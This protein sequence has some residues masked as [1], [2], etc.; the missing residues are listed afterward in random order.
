MN[1]HNKAIKILSKEHGQKI[2]QFLIDNGI[3]IDG[4]DI[5][6]NKQDNKCYI[7]G[8]QNNTIY[9]VYSFDNLPSK[10]EFFELP[11][12][13]SFPRMMLVWDDNESDVVPRLVL[14]KSKYNVN[15]P[16]MTL[17]YIDNEKEA[18]EKFNSGEIMK[19]RFCKYAKE[20][21]QSQIEV[22][23]MTLEQVCKILGKEIKIIK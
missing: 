11:E 17:S 21:E 4:W 6:C 20:I 16:F 22:E 12:K 10:Y 8:I 1:L 5:N 18:F 14:D 13:K 9:D 3:N 2:K 19:V 15:Y 23:E 7:Y